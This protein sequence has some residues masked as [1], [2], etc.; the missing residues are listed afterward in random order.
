MGLSHGWRGQGGKA[1][2]TT[3]KATARGR[4]TP[5]P[6]PGSPVPHRIWAALLRVDRQAG[7]C[8]VHWWGTRGSE[9]KEVTCLQMCRPGTQTQACH[10]P[11]ACSFTKTEGMATG[12]S[13][14]TPQHLPKRNKNMSTQ[15]LCS[16]TDHGQ[17]GE[18]THSAPADGWVNKT[19][20]VHTRE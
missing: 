18:T 19:W 2:I 14:S 16:T 4:T 1:G 3:S 8:P 9:S 11:A 17:K 5:L 13:N 12:P 10:A 6:P 20:S 15:D 7:Q